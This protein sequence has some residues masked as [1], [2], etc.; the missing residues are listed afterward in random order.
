MDNIKKILLQPE[1]E[2]YHSLLTAYGEDIIEKL[3]EKLMTISY[4]EDLR[5]LE[6]GARDATVESITF[7]DDGKGNVTMTLRSSSTMTDDGSS[8]VTVTEVT[9][10]D[11]GNGNVYIS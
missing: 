3:K 6:F 2:Y 4:D 5:I 10:R 8:N 1:F 7:S 11:D 9:F